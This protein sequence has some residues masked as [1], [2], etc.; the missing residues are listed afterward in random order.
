M[1]EIFYKVLLLV[2][3]CD[4]KGLCCF[5]IYMYGCTV[6]YTVILIIL[7]KFNIELL[8]VVDRK[9][10]VLCNIVI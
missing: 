2:N 9:K 7:K 3:L 5:L 6:M 8:F 10:F 4:K 1:L